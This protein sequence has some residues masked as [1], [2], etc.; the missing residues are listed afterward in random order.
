MNVLMNAP[1]IV[2]TGVHARMNTAIMYALIAAKY[3]LLSGVNVEFLIWLWRSTTSRPSP[4]E[5]WS[6]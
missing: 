2:L 5:S 1:M 4:I 3:I 6:Y